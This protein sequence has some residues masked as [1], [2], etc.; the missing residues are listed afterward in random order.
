LGGTTMQRSTTAQIAGS[1]RTFLTDALGVNG[2]NTA[3]TFLSVSTPAPHSS[4]LSYFSRVRWTIADK[5][6]FTVSGRVDGSS[7]FGAGHRYGFFPAASF[8]WRASDEAFVKRLGVFDDLKLRASYGR[9]GNQD[10]GNYNS[11][12]VLNNTVS[13][14]GGERAI[15]FAPSSLANP[16]L[17]WETTDG[18]DF[19]IDATMLRSRVSVTAD[20][21]YKKT[22]DLLY[23]V[24][25]PQTTGFST[26]LQNIGT[27]QN[28]GFEV[29]LTTNNL[30]GERLAWQTTLNLAWN[31]NKVLNLGGDDIIVGAFPYVG[32]G[33]H[34][35]P[36]VL[37][38]G[39]PINS[40]YGW[41]YDGLARD[42]LGILRP[43]YKD[44][45]GDGHDDGP[46]DERILGNAEPK[47][48]GGLNNRFTFRNFELS[49]F[50]QWS[51]GNKIYNINRSL[52]TAAGGTVNQLQ[53]VMSGR[54]PK[55][56][57]TFESR[58]SNLFV[59]DGSY[60]RGKNLRLGYSVPTAWLDAMHLKGMT[61]LQL[62]ISAQNFF[63]VTNYTGYDPEISEYA[64]TNLA[65]GI[66]FGTYPQV[67]Q[68]T[69]GFT[70]GF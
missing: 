65:Q 30:T 49:V 37:K 9:T 29:S 46:G 24:S 50:L 23:Y 43:V 63:T 11:L 44:L 32:G 2:L 57:N 25:V 31:R 41:V 51:V 27:V 55:I 26:S 20:Y 10:I 17:K 12:A 5:Y 33:A 66:D 34:Q 68:I 52:L 38:V 1:S 36:T 7:K 19:G 35:N 48:T 70:A 58:E 47:Y 16:D 13:V 14:F 6:L 59:E 67:R 22:R 28:R 54:D 3:K 56:G 42:T 60:L 39:E 18:V 53:D 4:L 64:S 45:D 8:A 21:Y 62:Y 15:G 61:R 40:F 69:F